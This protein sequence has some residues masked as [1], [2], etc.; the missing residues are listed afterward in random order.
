MRTDGTSVKLFFVPELISMS[1][2]KCLAKPV[3]SPLVN[4]GSRGADGAEN[5]WAGFSPRK[6]WLLRADAR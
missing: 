1:S 4:P 2:G 3:G 5:A 6:F